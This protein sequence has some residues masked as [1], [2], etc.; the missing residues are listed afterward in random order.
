MA[1]VGG[2]VIDSILSNRKKLIEKNGFAKLHIL[3]SASKIV[4]VPVIIF[5]AR[6][7]VYKR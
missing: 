1:L 2:I 5:A 6:V 4:A 7:P 3:I